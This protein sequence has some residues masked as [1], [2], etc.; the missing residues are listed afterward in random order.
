MVQDLDQC[1]EPSSSSC[2]YGELQSRVSYFLGPLSLLCPIGT[3]I[4]LKT[5]PPNTISWLPSNLV[6]GGYYCGTLQC[7]FVH[8]I[9]PK[10]LL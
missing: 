3:K 1:C 10:S 8:S 5:L 6:T 4:G 9:E 2:E 7:V